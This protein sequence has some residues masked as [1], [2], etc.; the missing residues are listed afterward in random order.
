M[1]K[2]PKENKGD[3]K[4]KF[5]E[6]IPNPGK[7]QSNAQNAFEPPAADT[8]RRNKIE[9]LR[10]ATQVRILRLKLPL[11]LLLRQLQ[12]RKSGRSADK[13]SSPGSGKSEPFRQHRMRALLQS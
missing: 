6:T 13:H 9:A 11:L 5:I 12:L 1:P 2:P 3:R 7:P 4:R 10:L 8:A